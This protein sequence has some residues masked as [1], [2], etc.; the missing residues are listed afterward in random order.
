M[1]ELHRW[2]EKHLSENKLFRRVP[3]E[4]LKDDICIKLIFNET[5]EG[6]KVERNKGNKF[7]CVYERI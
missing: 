2:H 3:D 1:E 6:K 5:E 4:N 7:F